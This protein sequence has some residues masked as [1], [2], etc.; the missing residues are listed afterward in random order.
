[1]KLRY[2]ILGVAVLLS[3]VF[4]FGRCNRTPAAVTRPTVLP[5]NDKEQIIVNPSNDTLEILQSGQKPQILTLPDTLTTVDIH[6][7][8][9]VKVTSPQFG[10]EH[11]LF[12]AGLASNKLRLGVGVDG[13]YYKRLDL[14]I[15]IADQFGE[16]TPIVFAKLTYTVKGNIQAG[17]EYG[18]D[19]YIGGIVSVRLF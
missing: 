16:H 8:G 9:S 19:R 14:G 13:L 18:T 6:K 4:L 10:L 5:N 11:H 7:D 12:V 1:M 17:L 2:K 3:T 15:G